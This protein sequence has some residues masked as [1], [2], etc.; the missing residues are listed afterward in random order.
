MKTELAQICESAKNSG[1][2]DDIEDF[3]NKIRCFGEQYSLEMLVALGKE[4]LLRVSNLDIDK[5][6]AALNSYPDL[7]EKIKSYQDR[8]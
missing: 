5:I 6:E 1:Y 8:K 2:F 4:L 3:A 7:V